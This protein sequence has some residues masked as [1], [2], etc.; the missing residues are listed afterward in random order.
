MK[1]KTNNFILNYQP[2][3][4]IITSPFE[5]NVELLVIGIKIKPIIG[6]G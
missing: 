3:Y 5:E 2:F 4:K 6:M 1:L